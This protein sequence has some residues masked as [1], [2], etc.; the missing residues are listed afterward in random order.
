MRLRRTALLVTGLLSI[1]ALPAHASVGWRVVASPEA[2]ARLAAVSFTGPSDGWAVGAKAGLDTLVEHWN[3]TGWREIASPAVAFSDE[4]LT[5]VSAVSGSDAWAVGW[6]DPYGT[7]RVHGLFV[8]WDGSGWSTVSAPPGIPVGVDARTASD[9]WAVGNDFYA[10][11]DGHGWSAVAPPEAG[12]HPAS[13]VVLAAN[14]A[15]AVGGRQDPRPGYHHDVPYLAHWN[16]TA[17]SSVPVPGNFGSGA[18]SSV[19][20][21]SANDIWAVGRVGSFPS[22]P[23]ALHFDGASWQVVP[24]VAKGG[25]GLS[26]VTAVAANDVWAV[27]QRDGTLPNGNAVLR[28]LIEHW[29]G[30]AWS[31]TRS[32]ND[33][34]QDNYFAAAD[35]AGGVVWA[36]GGDGGTLIARHGA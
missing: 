7:T 13:V 12:T 4:A 5:G 27:G 16:G 21:I 9:I 24:T 23:V 26:G 1:S 22:T 18:L 25:S 31:T 35:T 14:N 28:T 17:W 19:S 8:H 15:W 30:S 29:D 2:D 6:Q 32:P 34:E 10:H 20:A 11:F 33:S 3:G 36:V